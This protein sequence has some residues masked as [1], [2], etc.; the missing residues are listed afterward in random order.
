M[1]NWLRYEITQQELTCHKTNNPL[2]HEKQLKLRWKKYFS[3]TNN[4]RHLCYKF[5][6]YQLILW[7]RCWFTESC[8]IKKGE[9]EMMIRCILNK[10]RINEKCRLFPLKQFW[11]NYGPPVTFVPPWLLNGWSEISIYLKKGHSSEGYPSHNHYKGRDL[12]VWS[13]VVKIVQV[14]STKD[15][16]DFQKKKKKVFYTLFFFFKPL[17]WFFAFP[18]VSY[19]SISLFICFLLYYSCSIQTN[20]HSFIPS[21]LPSCPDSYQLNAPGGLTI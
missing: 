21:F 4:N 1:S 15:Y 13:F 3:K 19:L 20:L 2:S 14:P 16:L 11:V 6:S 18:V 8:E 10:V 12:H 7:D 5:D 17:S 9:T